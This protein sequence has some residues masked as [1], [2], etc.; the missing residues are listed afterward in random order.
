M[1]HR[2][3]NI[4]KDVM[5]LIVEQDFLQHFPAEQIEVLLKKMI[6]ASIAAY[7]ELWP[8]SELGSSCLSLDDALDDSFGVAFKVEIIVR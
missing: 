4:E 5:T 1:L 2:H 8:N 6:K 7:F 3:S